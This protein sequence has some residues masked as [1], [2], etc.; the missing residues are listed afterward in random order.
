VLRL[1]PLKPPDRRHRLMDLGVDSLMAVE[2]RN[3][4]TVGLGLARPLPATL[5][6][7]YP[8]IDAIAAHLRQEA[9]ALSPTQP[10]AA[11]PAATPAPP[12]PARS[13]DEVAQ[14]S[15]QEVEALLLQRLESL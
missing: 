15:D 2:L 8:T 3:R 9:L 13:E 1:D 12:T 10:D 5:M 6:F 14:M 4:L 7:D 11:A